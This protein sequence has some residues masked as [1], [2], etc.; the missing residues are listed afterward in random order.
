MFPV[1]NSLTF[2]RILGIIV[3]LFFIAGAFARFR[4]HLIKRWEFVALSLLGAALSTVAIYPNT[5]NLVAGMFALN[6][7]QYGRLITL[8]LLSNFLIWILVLSIRGKNYGRDIQF[9]LLVRSIAQQKY[10]T[11][12]SAEQIKKITVIM[13]ALDEAENLDVLLPK[14]PTT[15]LGEPLGVL[16]IDDGSFDDTAAVVRKHRFAV[17]CN[18]INRG[19]GA[20]LRL[21]YDIAVENGAQIVVTMDAD[22]QHLP[23]EIEGLVKPILDNSADVVI[24]SRVKGKREKDSLVRWVGIH[25]FSAMINFLAGTNISDCSNGFRAFRVDSLKKI[26]LTHDQFHTA[27]LIIEAARKKMRITE[28]PVTVL[29]RFQ[30]QSK[31][32]RNLS[33]GTNFFKSIIKAWFR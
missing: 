26:L 27:E 22:G 6:N 9:D 1:A 12:F 30:G 24:G 25:V 5:I 14:I 29:K 10:S 18:P 4:F 3:G 8:L 13:P 23:E 16:V 33:Y 17:A 21:G 32:G 11:D 19:G 2:L 28:A 20:S 31:K 7:A 15:V